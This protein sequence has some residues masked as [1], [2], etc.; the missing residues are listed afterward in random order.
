METKKQA[1]PTKKPGFV[2]SNA[3][4][5]CSP[6]CPRLKFAKQLSPGLEIGTRAYLTWSVYLCKVLCI[7]NMFILGENGSALCP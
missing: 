2:F 4:E 7:K 1:V 3:V 6:K 5:N